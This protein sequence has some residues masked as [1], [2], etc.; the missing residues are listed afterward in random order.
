MGAQCT[1]RCTVHDALPGARQT[2][3]S[4]EDFLR[5]REYITEAFAPLVEICRDLNRCMRI[6][7]AGL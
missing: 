6:G 4:N 2:Y 5:D 1:A 3:E 7:A